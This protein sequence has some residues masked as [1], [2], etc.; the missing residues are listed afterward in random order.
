MN[1]VIFGLETTT[2]VKT[3]GAVL[4]VFGVLLAVFTY[5]YWKSARPEPE[6]LA[7][8]EV[9]SAKRFATTDPLD[10]QR[11]LDEVRPEGMVAPKETV[12][13]AMQAVVMAT[14]AEKIEAGRLASER[15][16]RER[17]LAENSEELLAQDADLPTRANAPIDPLLG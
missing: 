8:L 6:A 13:M 7:P 15:A 5:F 17:R 14:Q 16:E 9:M 10:Q 11:L 1:L 12:R 3:V 4:V 2:A